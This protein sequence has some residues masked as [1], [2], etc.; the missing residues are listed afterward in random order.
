M[1]WDD[2]RVFLAVC[3]ES[4]LRGAARVLGVDQATVGRRVN[5]LEKS[6]NATLF[7]RTSE[8]Y[9]L[10]AVG[11]AALQSVE[12]MERSALDLERQVLGLDDRLTGTVRVTTTD[13]LAID[14]LIPAIARLHDAH[15]DVRVQMDA[16]T[17]L[18]NL[19]KREADIAVRNTRP[20][21]PDLIARRIAR[22]PV[23]LFASQAYIDR[24]GA[25]EPGSL[26][27]GHDLVVYQPHLQSQKDLTLVSEPLGRGRI[28]AALSSSL[29]VRRSIAAGIGIGEVPIVSGER[30]GL[31]RLWPDR[32][33]PLPY[34]V[35]LV[36]H[37][38]L[39]HTARVRVVID[40][41]VAGF[42]GTG[43]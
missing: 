29:L 37:A 12:N 31:V 27:E 32:T 36:T 2:A 14:F 42:A 17:Q 22:W 10:T 9:A 3:R 6:L 18:L 15:P 23:G 41:I 28:V 25:P 35:W 30:D 26:F 34:D 1:N 39:R 40:E 20:D 24:H 19:A 4:T 16:S 11:E 33:R 38:D 21:N 13:S 7:L 8:G 5:A 43:E